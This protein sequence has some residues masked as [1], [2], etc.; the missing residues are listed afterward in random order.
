[1]T[2]FE[3]A[4]WLVALHFAAD[5]HLQSDFVATS[6]VPG[7]GAIWPWVMTAH[8]AL[9][10]LFVALVLGPWLGLA[11]FVTHWLIDLAKSRGWLGTG[12]NGFVID[13]SLHLVLKGVWIATAP[14]MAGTG[15]LSSIS[16]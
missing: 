11:E 13:Q 5:Y 14:F 2:V 12:S 7:T 1:M 16:F 10:G 8:A 6:K 4:F 9:H 3:Q 15:L